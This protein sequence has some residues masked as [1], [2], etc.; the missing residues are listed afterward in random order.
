MVPDVQYIRFL[1]PV[2]FS[3]KAV[4]KLTK[5]KSKVPNWYLD[6][7]MITNYS[8]TTALEPIDCLI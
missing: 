3:S 1:S 6:L 4:E 8:T 2:S 5:R 7:S